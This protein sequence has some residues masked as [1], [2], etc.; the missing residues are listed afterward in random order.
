MADDP[1]TFA[2]GDAEGASRYLVVRLR[3]AL[4]TDTASC[5][6]MGLSRLFSAAENGDLDAAQKAELGA[7]S[8]RLHDARLL[9]TENTDQDDDGG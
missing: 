9:L 2:A 7:V 6:A 4:G 5:V 8:M 1:L 3:A